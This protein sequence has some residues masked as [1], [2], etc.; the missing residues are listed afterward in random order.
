[1]QQYLGVKP[2]GLVA[3][4]A[5]ATPRIEEE[6]SGEQEQGGEVLEEDVPMARVPEPEQKEH[7]EHKEEAEV[8]GS[9]EGEDL[10]KKRQKR[11]RR[12]ERRTQQFWQKRGRRP[13]KS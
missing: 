6:E 13:G 11:A 12:A 3:D 2:K 8:A 10:P 5:G 4:E 9:C 7:E 1:M